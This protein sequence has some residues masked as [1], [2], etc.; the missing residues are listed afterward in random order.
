MLHECLIFLKK[1]RNFE[2]LLLF[3]LKDFLL[4][5]FENIHLDFQHLM[6][7]S[8]RPYTYLHKHLRYAYL[9]KLNKQ[10]ICVKY[11]HKPVFHYRRKVMSFSLF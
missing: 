9:H 4:F 3:K 10:L 7:L 2:F 8:F 11:S 1:L 6:K 5:W